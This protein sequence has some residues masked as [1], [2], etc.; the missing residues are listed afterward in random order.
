MW[1]IKNHK[2][3]QNY[4]KIIRLKCIQVPCLNPP[5]RSSMAD[6]YNVA[7]ANYLYVFCNNDSYYPCYS[8]NCP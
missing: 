2:L 6:S 5:S 3:K 8:T 1:L 7:Y 4:C